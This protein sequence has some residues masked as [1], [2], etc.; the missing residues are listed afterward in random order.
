MFLGNAKNEALAYSSSFMSVV[1]FVIA[2]SVICIPT[3]MEDFINI[4]VSKYIM[5][6]LPG[7]ILTLGLEFLIVFLKYRKIRFVKFS[8]PKKIYIFFFIIIIPILEEILYLTCLYGICCELGISGYIFILL[9]ALGFGIGHFRYPKINMLT[10]SIW[11]L[12]FAI[13]YLMTKSLYLVILLHIINNVTLY[14][15]GRCNIFISRNQK[16]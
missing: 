3:V 14:V 2:Y 5:L 16:C 8:A 7:C 10:K 6:L 12:F 4:N 9:S 11:G 15:L 1:A 13:I